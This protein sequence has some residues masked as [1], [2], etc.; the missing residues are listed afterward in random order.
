VLE[1]F[2]F[3]VAVAKGTRERPLSTPEDL[4][5]AKI[6]NLTTKAKEYGINIGDTGKEALEKLLR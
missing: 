1:E 2:G 4:L 5:N 6:V 3:A